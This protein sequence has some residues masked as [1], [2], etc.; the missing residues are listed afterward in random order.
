MWNHRLVYR[1]DTTDF[2]DSD[3][4]TRRYSELSERDRWLT[5]FGDGC[6]S[7]PQ[8]RE[9][10]PEIQ[11]VSLTDSNKCGTWVSFGL[12]FSL[13]NSGPCLESLRTLTVGILTLFYLLDFSIHDFYRLFHKWNLLFTRT[14]SI[15]TCKLASAQHL[16]RIDTW[17][18]AWTLPNS[19]GNLSRCSMGTFRSIVLVG[20][21]ILGAK[22][23][24]FP[25]STTPFQVNSKGLWSPTVNSKGLC[26]LSE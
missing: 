17:G 11:V 8:L 10:R 2:L 22:F 12:F 15:G 26:H 20:S 25:N 9:F 4:H 14:S 19:C 18:V 7:I 24:L 13:V 21:S 3:I 23:P 16:F 6:H 5:G 1:I